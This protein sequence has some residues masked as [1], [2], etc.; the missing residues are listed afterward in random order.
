MTIAKRLALLLALP[1]VVL[2]ALGGYL[3][4]QMNGIEKKSRFVSDMQ[5]ESLAALGNIASHNT[6]MRV[7][8]RNYL[9]AD[10]AAE[11]AGPAADLAKQSEEMKSLLDHYGDTLVSGDADRRLYAEFRQLSHEWAVESKRLLELAANGHRREARAEMV[12]GDVLGLGKRLGDVLAEWIAHNQMLARQSGQAAVDAIQ[13]SEKNLIL[14]VGAAMLLSWALGYF[15]FRRI[16]HPIRGLQTTVKSIA[17]GD[18]T[19]AVPFTTDPGE[20]GDLAR[21]IAVLKQGAAETAEQR[22]VKASVAKLSSMLQRAESVQ[23]FGEQ[24]LS[25]TVPLVACGA[26]AFYVFEKDRGRLR[27]AASYGLADGGGAESIAVGEGLSGEAVRQRVPI[28]VGNL[29]PA[30]LRIS[31]GLGS[32]DPV[33]AIAWPVL[34]RNSVLGVLELAAFR[35]LNASEKTL[36]EELMPVVAMNLEILERNLG[37]QELLVQTQ[38]QAKRLEAQTDALTSSQE[39]L[40]A[41]KEELLARQQELTEQ[42]EQ[43]KDSEERSRLILESTAD[44]IFGTDPEGRITFV[45]P[46]ACQMLGF[47]HDE[48][49]GQ[50]SHATFHHR[51]ADG[52]EYPK[53]ECP[54]FA[55]YKHGRSSHVDNEFLWRKDGSGFPVEYGAR[56]VFKDGTLIASVV[57]FT[58]ITERRRAEERLR[59]TEQFFRSVLESAPDALMVVDHHGVMQLANAQTE[60]VF[61]YTRDELV[62]QAVEMLVPE[63]V[64][65]GHA[66]LRAGYHN[67]PAARAM[68]VGQELSG[69]RKDGSEFPVEI[70]LS[71]LPAR[72]SEPPQVA[73]SIRD[74]TV[75]KQQERQIIEAR[76]KAE[77]ATAAKSMFLANMSHEIRTPM[78]AIIGMTHLA[79]KT[80][81]TPKQFDYLTKVRSAAGTLLG[82]INDILD[83]SKIEAGK[84]DIENAEFRFED[85]LQNLSTVVGQKAQEKNL[86]FLISAQPEIPPNLVGDPLRIGQILINLVNNAVKFTERG[87]VVVSVGIEERAS[88]RVKLAFS[89]RDTGIGMTPEQLS[90]LFQAFS[91]ADTSTTRKFGGTGLGLS[92]SKRLVEMMGGHIWAESE[93]GKGSTFQFNAWF[94]IGAEQ[95]HKRFV[96]DMAGFRALVV[97]DNAQAREILSDALRGFALRADTVA[98]GREAIQAV[99]GADSSD[100]YH[101]VLM[102][103]N[104]PEMD[105]IQATAIL[106]RD[107]GL[108]NSPRVAMVTAF[109]REEIRSQAEQVGIDAFLMKPVS[110]SVLYDTLM[111]MFGAESLEGAGG[112]SHKPGA[113]EHDARGVRVLLVEDNDMN[114]QVATELLESAGATVKVA[115]HGG[116]AVKLLQDGPQPP[117]FDIVLMDLQMPE[118]DGFTATRILRADPRFKDLPIVAMTAHALVEER[119]RCLQAGMVDHI[120]K[121]ID[122]DALF[123]TLARWT[124][125]RET[126]VATAKPQPAPA[127]KE[128]PHIE[129]IDI[130]GGLKRVAGNKRLYRSLLQQFVAK[131]ADTPARIEEALGKGDRES[132]E[133][134]AHTLKGVAGNIGIGVVQAA[135][136]KVEKAIRDGDTSV[137]VLAALKS[138]LGPQVESIRTALGEAAPAA[139]QAEAF[140]REA[141]AAAVARLMSLIEA[142]DGDAA[143]AVEEVAAALTGK[144]ETGRLAELRESVAG[145][146]FDDARTKLT[147]IAADCHLT[148]GQKDDER[149]RETTH[150]AG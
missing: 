129:G 7:N 130:D 142:N 34:T 5:I 70:G 135:A 20:T 76:E 17:A 18:Y 125:Q 146:D 89:V 140:N 50:P 12:S 122:P 138:V 8:V 127:D 31:S 137:E 21:S 22:W 73:V 59:E 149:R 113:A 56:P 38:D 78:N 109:G 1:I 35:E 134:L 37:T 95:Q 10:E 29:P 107:S 60:R 9:L 106:R 49:L 55:A 2:I 79:L 102:D 68:G 111:E 43:L 13:A 52:S 16:V 82:I 116:I 97:D 42:R 124:K 48:L 6:D 71:P 112:V 54:M 53:E 85:V 115:D 63:N 141:A 11:A 105:G 117:P 136:A 104:M 58:D 139:V 119:E 46:A 62:G 15:T 4:F 133:R 144:V 103:W 83:F 61:G 93:A 145:F 91:Q 80:D 72:G 3:F 90:R 39:E 65:P 27:R 19:Q 99:K 28:T 47:T 26:A 51:R 86:E 75:R 114:Q 44:G 57:S 36:F 64:R 120:T 110:P 81:L 123:A 118:M 131:Q 41:Q 25:G 30:Y 23:G 94:G 33:Q 69:L 66:A 84:L 40:M 45:N 128:L 148:F 74:I 98:S 88:D 32:T 108:K 147:Q 92:I 150:S 100:P 67:V 143:D 121:P 24:L 132:A 126:P 14:A 96:P 101:L 87:E 77:E